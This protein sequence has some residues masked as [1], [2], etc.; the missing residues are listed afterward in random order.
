[1]NMRKG[2]CVICGLALAGALA[3]G[4]MPV[5]SQAGSSAASSATPA[6][7]YITSVHQAFSTIDV[8]MEDMR[9]AAEAADVAAVY[10]AL[11][12]VDAQVAEIEKL[13]VP[14][15]LEEVQAK[16]AGA[17]KNLAETLRAYAAYRLD[18]GASATDAATKLAAIQ[19]DYK[20]GIEALR[21]ADEIAKGL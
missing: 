19:A 14:E 8:Q 6:S 1:M 7:A 17:S 2:A 13:T 20:E 10:A 16:Y 15:G 9:K 12:K 3:T 5:S 21:A 11:N 18:G 4:C